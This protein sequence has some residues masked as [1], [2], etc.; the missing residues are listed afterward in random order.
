[1]DEERENGSM[2]NTT[3]HSSLWVQEGN[4]EIE[5]ISLLE[6]IPQLEENAEMIT[7]KVLDE[8]TEFS[9]PGIKTIPEVKVS[10]LYTHSQHKKLMSKRNKLL[11]IFVKYPDETA[12]VE[13][14][15]LV[16]SFQGKIDVVGDTITAGEFLKDIVAIYRKTAITETDGFPE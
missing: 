7:A 2:P 9:E 1:M 6:E 4:G 16:K 13:G 12:L 10:Q 14:K 5:Q 15:P 11:N 3:T 8:E